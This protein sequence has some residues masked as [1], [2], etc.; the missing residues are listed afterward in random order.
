VAYVELKINRYGQMVRVIDTRKVATE[1]IEHW[2][3]TS[4]GDSQS[5]IDE[6]DRSLKEIVIL[7]CDA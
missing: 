4:D 1:I 5:L 7:L 2:S 6:L 3:A